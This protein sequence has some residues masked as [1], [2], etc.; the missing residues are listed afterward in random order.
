MLIGKSAGKTW[1]YIVGV[2]LGDGCVTDHKTKRGGV[3]PT[4]RLNTID[5]DFALATKAALQNHTS[6]AVGIW[7]H[8][9]SK[10]SKPNNA[11][12][13][14]D[15]VICRELI[16]ETDRKQKLPD[17]IWTADHDGLLAFISGLMD[18]EGYVCING[19]GSTNMGYLST[20][21]WFDDFVRVLNKA[22]IQIGKI[23][24]LKPFKAHYKTPKRFT[25]KMASWVNSGARFNIA[26]K[27]ARVDKWLASQVTSE[28]NT[29]TAAKRGDD[30]AQSTVRAVEGVL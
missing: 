19:S 6:Y 30:R 16:A 11:L 27:N 13:C 17:W 4:F 5:M 22:G 3:Y 28:T 25:I 21:V 1:E 15:P 9:V 24:V 26:R 14:Y 2:Y 8:A 29:P 12:Q 7:T 18:S 23:G 10:S 20:D